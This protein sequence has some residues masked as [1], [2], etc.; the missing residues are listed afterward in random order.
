TE[1]RLR[2]EGVALDFTPPPAPVRVRGGEVRLQQ[3]VLN[4][5]AN[6]LD[7]MAGRQDRALT[8][9]IVPGNPVQLTCRDTGPGIAEPERVFDPFYT[10]K[11]AGQAEG[12][13]LGLAISDRIIQS[14]GGRILARNTEGGGALFIVELIGAPAREAA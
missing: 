3:V 9:R 11:E 1:P 13:G 7:A 12:M 4:I 14:F 2:Q 8:L 10:T 6:A 5:L